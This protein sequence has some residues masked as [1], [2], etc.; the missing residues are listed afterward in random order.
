MA[1]TRAGIAGIIDHTLLAPESTDAQ[2]ASL[3]LEAI[4]LEVAAVCINATR[5]PLSVQLPPGLQVAA[6]VGFPSGA[7]PTS[8]KVV[9][10]EAVVAGGAT[11]VDVVVDLAAAVSGDWAAVAREL[12]AIRAAIGPAVTIK[13]ILETALLTPAA[14]AEGCRA[15]EDAGGDFVKTSSGFHPAGGASVEAVEVMAATVGGRLGIKAAGGIRTAETALRMVD[16]GATRLGCSASAAVLA[17][18]PA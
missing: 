6:V 12:T 9:E 1:R 2:V 17:G 15:V 4:D 3:C 18:L 8:V 14:I 13:A 16:A 5:L 10:A 7:H 11:E